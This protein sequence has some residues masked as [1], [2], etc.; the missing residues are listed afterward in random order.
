MD[1]PHTITRSSEVLGAMTPDSR[2]W[3]RIAAGG[4]AL[5]APVLFYQ[6]VSL[7]ASPWS[8]D[9][10]S[11]LVG[12]G[13]VLTLLSAAAV[14]T[15]LLAPGRSRAS[16]RGSRK[17]DDAIATLKRRYATGEISEEEFERRLEDL[18]AADAATDDGTAVR[19]GG[20]A[21]QTARDRSL[22]AAR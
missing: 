6:T 22:D 10:P 5:A 1:E 15:V 8:G 21:E 13:V 7:I 3:R 4:A 11:L 12:L 2:R 20:E 19:S 17:E 9:L 18:V 16:R 14:P